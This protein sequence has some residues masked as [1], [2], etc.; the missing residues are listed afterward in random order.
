MD[1]T[2]SHGKLLKV[3]YI[4]DGKPARFTPFQKNEINIGR[5][6]LKVAFSDVLVLQEASAK[7][8]ESQ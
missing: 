8:L 3:D 7:L 4:D 2:F 5:T 1:I 6:F